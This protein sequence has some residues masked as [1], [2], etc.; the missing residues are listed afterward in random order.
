[1][2]IQQA[3]IAE[4]CTTIFRLNDQR[5]MN[6]IRESG[7]QLKMSDVQGNWSV[8]ICRR[9][10]DSFRAHMSLEGCFSDSCRQGLKTP[11]DHQ[12]E[13]TESSILVFPKGASVSDGGTP[14]LLEI[15][16]KTNLLGIK[17]HIQA[18]DGIDED[19]D[20]DEEVPTRISVY[21]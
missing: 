2:L 13:A 6:F 7:I 8:M 14:L 20:G 1:V 21:L 11:L 16:V 15:D 3:I 9:V 10:H 5:T 12:Q 18:R 17:A 4:D 19:G